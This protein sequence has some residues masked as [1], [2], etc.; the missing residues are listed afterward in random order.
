VLDAIE[1]FLRMKEPR[2]PKTYASYFGVLK[3]SERGTKPSLGTPLGAFLQNQ[4]LD[5]VTDDDV[6]RWYAQRV[7]NARQD[8]K[9]R[10]SR[11][12]RE[13][14]AFCFERGYTPHDLGRAI[15]VHRAGRARVD[16]LEW[17]D[18]HRLLQAVPEFRL[19]MAA[20]WLFFT[21]CR[22]SEATRARQ[23]D[24]LFRNSTNLYE[25]QI[26][27]TKTDK[28]R[29][30]WLPDV[31]GEYIERSRKQNKPSPEWPVLWDCEGHGF[32]R[33]ESP[34]APISDRSIN[35]ALRRACEE[36]G[37]PIHVTNH[38]GRHTY[39]TNWVA[40]HGA[41]ELALEKLSRQVGASVEVLR[42]TYVHVQ[43]SDSDFAAVR[44]F[45]APKRT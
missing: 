1:E 23:S 45:G 22:V 18:V 9:S 17:E 37:L 39:C 29:A 13:F 20:A 12:A 10:I 36:I 31:L 6:A 2:A 43:F 35:A 25:W 34:V 40:E 3:G 27:E 7:K 44:S 38:V 26:P 4:R 21:G 42:K 15:E 32:G 8:T 14:F 16:W 30:V 19:R 33:V 5:R 11:Q 24:V 28:A 41:N